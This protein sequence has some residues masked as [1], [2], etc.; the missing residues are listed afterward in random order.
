MAKIPRL[1]LVA[2]IL[3]A[4]SLA[5]YVGGVLVGRAQAKSGFNQVLASVQL[6]LGQTRLERLQELESDL[7]R[8][9]NDVALA[10]VRIDTQVQMVVLSGIYKDHKGTW[11]VES[12]TKR[13]PTL[14][15]K[16]AGFQ[17]TSNSWSVPKC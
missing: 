9:C 2:A 7:T 6:E 13:D 16:L 5:S 12:I 10:K 17:L 3:I 8:S 11:V 14:P 1:L 4:T 15:E